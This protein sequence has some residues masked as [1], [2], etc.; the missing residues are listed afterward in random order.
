MKTATITHPALVALQGRLK[1]IRDY[2]A[3]NGRNHETPAVRAI[4]DEADAAIAE[5]DQWLTAPPPSPKPHDAEYW[6]A[7]PPVQWCGA[8]EQIHTA[9][10]AEEASKA[11]DHL[12]ERA[13]R[14]R[15]YLWARQCGDHAYGVRRSNALARKI[16]RVLG[17]S[18]PKQDLQF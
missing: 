15:G 11:L 6:I 8:V 1:G 16:R 10:A 18:Y 2:A 12:I 9:N 7:L 3:H 14:A 13:A 4:R 17:Y 5:I